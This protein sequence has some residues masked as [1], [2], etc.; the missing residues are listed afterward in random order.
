M[1]PF[2]LNVRGFRQNGDEQTKTRH[3]ITPSQ[4]KERGETAHRQMNDKTRHRKKG[5][6]EKKQD[7][8]SNVG[9]KLEGRKNERQRGRERERRE[10]DTS[11]NHW[12]SRRRG[13]KSS[14]TIAVKFLSQIVSLR[15]EMW[16]RKSLPLS[17]LFPLARSLAIFEWAPAEA[18]EN[19]S[20]NA[21]TQ[22][23]LTCVGPHA[24]V[25]VEAHHIGF[26]DFLFS[27]DQKW[28]PFFFFF[29]F[30]WAERILVFFFSFVNTT[31]NLKPVCL[32]WIGSELIFE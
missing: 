10:K 24:T 3:R 26:L 14:E 23:F 11:G 16:H 12:G 6:R 7:R 9:A 29:C 1:N 19:V 31:K 8:W 15:C 17:P 25:I 4:P 2:E 28:I 20:I 5:K 13:W 18:L 32:W 30:Y 21:G 22:R 27:S